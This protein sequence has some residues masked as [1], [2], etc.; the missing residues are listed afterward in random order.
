[1]RG[2]RFGLFRKA[3]F[4]ED[5]DAVRMRVSLGN[6]PRQAI[7]DGHVVPLQQAQERSLTV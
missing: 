3:R 6:P 4:I 2:D 1:L 7:A 5:A